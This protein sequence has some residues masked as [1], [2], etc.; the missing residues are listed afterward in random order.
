MPS[1]DL[2]V[3]RVK[4][5]HVRQWAMEYASAHGG[6]TFEDLTTMSKHQHGKDKMYSYVTELLPKVMEVLAGFYRQENYFV[7]RETFDVTELGEMN[8]LVTMFI[9]GYEQYEMELN[10]L[11]GDSCSASKNILYDV[12]PYLVKVLL[13]DGIWFINELEDCFVSR[14]LA[15][16]LGSSYVEWAKQKYPIMKEMEEDHRKRSK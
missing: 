8:D 7:P 1:T 4:T 6:I 2:L 10:S 14:F 15:L 9:P 16:T 11:E 12:F 5:T 13:Q 3:V